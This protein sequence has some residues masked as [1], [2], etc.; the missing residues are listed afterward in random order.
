[1]GNSGQA[2]VVWGKPD[3]DPI[4]LADVIAGVGGFAIDGEQGLDQAGDAVARAGDVDG[5]GLADLV[6]GAPGAEGDINLVGRSYVVLGK[7]DGALVDLV[8]IVAGV[9]GFVVE[10]EL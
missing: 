5:D 1:G 4:D 9:G 2:Y 3:G 6:L 8:D 10:G 7:D